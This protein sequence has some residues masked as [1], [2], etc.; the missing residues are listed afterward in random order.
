MDACLHVE[1]LVDQYMIVETYSR[2]SEDSRLIRK[3]PTL[4]EKEYLN[5]QEYR[6]KCYSVLLMELDISKQLGN[7]LHHDQTNTEWKGQHEGRSLMLALT[8]LSN[9]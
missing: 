7:D 6:I 2:F 9:P 5:V 4:V 3:L 8:E 1:E